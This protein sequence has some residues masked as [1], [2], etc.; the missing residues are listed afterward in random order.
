MTSR[1]APWTA[2]S[3][4]IIIT[5]LISHSLTCPP[6]EYLIDDKCCTMCP[7][8]N[9]VKTHCRAHIRTSCVS[10]SE[11]TYMD[12]P[13]GR[14]QCHRCADCAGPGLKVRSSCTETS[15]TVCEPMEGFDCTDFKGK[16]CATTQKHRSCKPGQYIQEKGTADTECSD[17]SDGTFSD[18]T[19]TSCQPH[20]QCEAENLQLIKAGT[21][22]DD[23]Q[24]GE[25]TNVA[26]TVGVSIPVVFL[27]GGLLAGAFILYKRTHHPGQNQSE[28]DHP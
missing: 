21:P 10:C 2:A 27:C 15:D 22:S 25:T 16:S 5:A 20:R 8:G 24:C 12:K 11:D 26:L 4:L 3:L 6:A 13:T 9:R 17:C 14:R 1:R 23:A 19:L 18:G 28:E 7:P